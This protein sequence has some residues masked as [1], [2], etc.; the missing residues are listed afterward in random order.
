MKIMTAYGGFT[1]KYDQNTSNSIFNIGD[2]DQV[3]SL[4]FNKNNFNRFY[5]SHMVVLVTTI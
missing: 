3:A 4:K 5:L 1:V 2:E